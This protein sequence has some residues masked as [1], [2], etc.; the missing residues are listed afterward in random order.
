MSEPHIK[1]IDGLWQALYKEDYSLSD[2][3]AEAANSFVCDL[4]RKIIL[5]D[6]RSQSVDLEDDEEDYEYTVFM[7]K[8]GKLYKVYA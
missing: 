4:N 8:D 7:G 2:A 3:N 6:L 1:M 5:D